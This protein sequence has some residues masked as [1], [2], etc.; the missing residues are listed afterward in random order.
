M[1]L[2]P[3]LFNADRSSLDH[4]M[5]S[6]V[7]FFFLIIFYSETAFISPKARERGV[8]TDSGTTKTDF[9]ALFPSMQK[10]RQRSR[11]LGKGLLA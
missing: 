5:I 4:G 8:K 11:G 10:C 3:C 9:I 1:C 2:H 7:F 6:Q